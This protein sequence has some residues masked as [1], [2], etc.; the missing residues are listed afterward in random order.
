MKRC[1]LIPL[2]GALVFAAATP[3]LAQWGRPDNRPSYGGV[4]SAEARRAAYD[5]GFREG[6]KEGE[7]DGRQRDRFDYR[8]E[9]DFQRADHGYHHN[10]GDVD[11]YRQ[12]FRTGFV[13]G[14]GQGYGRST[15]GY[16]PKPGYYAPAFD[17][18]A[19]DGFEK[20]RE[21]ARDNDRFDTR[22]HKWYRDAERHYENEY[23]S[24]ERYKDE[25]R[26]GFLV[27]YEQG[28]RGAYYR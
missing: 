1:F 25:Y 22:R 12:A 19:R 7:K 24:K 27:G 5:N 15:G 20:G 28:Y 10:F 8:D 2:A 16:V 3:A 6:V 9:K 21:D 4:P 18:G 13:D 23:G 17:N 26:R 11:R 14:Y